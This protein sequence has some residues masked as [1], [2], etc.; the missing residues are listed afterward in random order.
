MNQLISLF[1][2]AL[3]TEPECA[4]TIEDF[5]RDVRGGR[6]ARKIEILRAHIS[7]GDRHRYDIK[8]RELPA[9]TLS[10]HCLSRERSLSPEAKDITHSGLLQ[11]DF[12]LKDNPMLMGEEAQEAMRVRLIEDPHVL[13][14][15]V[16]P[17]GEG[18]KIVIPIDPDRHTDSWFAAAEYFR[19]HYGL[20]LDRAT[21]DPLRLCFVSHDPAALWKPE[22]A[23]LPLPETTH[24]PT[25]E[26]KPPVE[27]TRDDILEMLSYIPKRP[28]YDTWLRIASAVWSVLP[29]EEGCQLLHQW[30]PEEKPGEYAAKHRARL[31][32]IGIGTLAHIASQHG[33][34]AREAYRR[35]RWAGRIR[36]ADS[37]RS[38][39][40]RCDELPEETTPPVLELTRDRVAKA[41]AGGQAGDA[42]LWCEIRSGIRLWNIHAK[43]WMC[44][45]DGLWSRD[46][47]LETRW[48][49]SD[50]LTAA[51][52][53][54]EETIRTEIRDA[55]P[56]D[57]RKDPRAKEI[58]GIAARCEKLATWEYLSGV[59][60]FAAAKIHAPATDFDHNPDILVLRNGT[61]DFAEGLFREHR[62]GDMATIR[63]PITFDPDATCPTWDAFLD[64]FIPE[65]DT[66]QY[67][68]RAVGYSLTGRVNADAMFFCYGK[69]A[70]GKSTFFS[71][72]KILL[73]DLM[74]TVPI[75]A[76]LASKSDNNFDYHK[77]SMEGKR[78]VLTDEIPEGRK[79]AEG[80]IKGLTGGDDINARRPYEQPYTF[81][82]THKLWL[83]GNHK[84][85]IRGT[86]E[87]IWRRVH[88][89]PF[90]VTIP[91]HE[92][93]PRD[94]V[95]ARFAA[96]AAGI[97]N[98]AIRGLLEYRDI[99]LCPPPEV[100][101]ATAEYREESDQ[102]GTF[103]T[104]C[105]VKSVTARC[106]AGSLGKCYTTWCEQNG[107]I[108]RYQ[109]TRQIRRV[110]I[111][112]GFH[113]ELDRD[114]HPE[115]WG[116][117]LKMEEPSNI[118]NLA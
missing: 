14:V 91:P 98:W 52:R 59:E 24:I 75:A 39:A 108:P 73:G 40:E 13:G 34:D 103:L 58:A 92:R 30:S 17:S 8:K 38:A 49:I 31:Q 99:G 45:E 110:M 106:K 115:I 80:Q 18:I 4:C 29:M 64:R 76:L 35:R 79:L 28:D 57:G 1:S 15:F 102:F 87:G 7:R 46:H 41:L 93:I 109:G 55:P 23:P 33:F 85:E 114:K 3:A 69:G 88:M 51:Y 56:P 37:T 6:W 82:P 48:E 44:Y 42:L 60:K 95:T 21:K 26:W 36:F 70:N 97:L 72:L 107:E 86:D 32:Q 101:A 89:I 94:E 83:M 112:R 67:L 90:L 27:T 84:P 9:V 71:C 104:E 100:V 22:A 113:V 54:L 43:V 53:G 16:G 25:A 61:L 74:T 11:G 12:D 77:A 2:N 65:P 66:R 19:V 81:R 20:H 62:P 68:A 63:S 47:G 50:T 5:L 105:T 117:A 116:L 10:C 111:D 118:L 78:V 96:E